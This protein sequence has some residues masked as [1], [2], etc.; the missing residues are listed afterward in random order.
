MTA[1]SVWIRLLGDPA[2]CEAWAA[3]I[4]AHG[5]VDELM[6]PFPNRRDPGVRLSL[7]VR[8]RSGAAPAAD[9]SSRMAV[10]DVMANPE[11]FVLEEALREYAASLRGDAGNGLNPQWC[12][13][14]AEAAELMLARI[15]D[16]ISR[17]P[18]ARHAGRN[19][20]PE[21]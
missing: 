2:A 14:R 3:V 15:E 19:P 20:C 13:E 16:A 17:K 5:D 21:T 18:P 4:A 11:G 7:T 9:G 1:G 12:R 8:A 6:G 10:F